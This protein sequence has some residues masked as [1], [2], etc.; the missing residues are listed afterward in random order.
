[1]WA[2]RVVGASYL[3]LFGWRLEGGLPP[4]LAKAVVIA[5]PH[6]T[7]W[8]LPFMLAVAYALGIRPSWLGKRE[9]FRWPFGW[10]MRALGGVPVDRSRRTN[11]VEQAVAR[12]DE[13]DRLFLVIPPSGTRSRAP[14]WKSGF[15]H[16]ARGARVPLV[17]AFLD[18]ERKVGGIG[19]VFVPTSDIGADMDRLRF[20]YR[21]VRGKYPDRETPVRLS[22]E[23]AAA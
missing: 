15:Y 16:V 8:D 9:L 4:G 13:A 11:V 7:N 14:H 5:A 22:E 2:L 21:D 17:C 23:D 20:F 6:T 3:K 18:Y 10:L 1:M 19:P 12:L